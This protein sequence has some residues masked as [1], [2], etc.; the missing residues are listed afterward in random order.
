[1]NGSAPRHPE[2]STMVAFIEGRLAPEELASVSDH[3]RGC[4]DCRTVVTETARFERQEQRA[5]PF[6]RPRRWWLAVAAVA[7]AIAITVPLLWNASRTSPIAHLIAALP[8]EHRTINARLAGFPWAPLQAPA[9]GN[10]APDPAD[11]KLIGAAG[12]VLEKAT[13]DTVASRHAAGLADLLIGRRT[14]AIAALEQAAKRSNDAK[15]WNDLAAARLVLAADDE[16]PSELT[17]AL[18]AADRALSLDP[19]SPEAH[20]NRALIL[21]HLGI[22][23]QAS[24]AWLAY[25]AIDA[26]SEW[27]VEARSHLSALEDHSGRFDRKLLDSMTAVALVRQFPAEARSYGEGLLLAEWAATHDEARLTLSR[28]IGAALVQSSGEC[29]L[30]D[31]VAAIDRANAS[32]RNALIEAYLL[33]R[34]ARIAYNARDAGA[35]E[36]KFVRAAQLFEKGGSPM[37]GVAN[38]YVAGAAFAGHRS[39][40]AVAVLIR[41]RSK[42]DPRHRALAAQIEW[43]LAVAANAGGD[44][45]SGVRAAGAGATMF[46]ALGEA[47]NA[48]VLD[49]IG[50]DALDAIGDAD[51]AWSRRIR[52]FAALTG[53]P[54]RARFLRMSA[55]ILDRFGRSEAAAS[56]SRLAIDDL[57]DDPAQR[58]A[59]LTDRAR[60]FEHEGDLAAAHVALG[61][62]RSAAG[63]IHDAAMRNLLSVSIDVTDA[64]IRRRGD[65]AAALAELDR[66]TRYFS[67]GRLGY[68]LPDIYLERARSHR[69]AGDD[70]AAVADYAAARREIETQRNTINDADLRLRILDTASQIVDETI[71][72]HLARGSVAEAFR[73][74]DETRELLGPRTASPSGEPEIA[75]GT[76][77]LE[78]AVLPHEIAVFC[79]TPQGM[80][81]ERIRN[82]RSALAARLSS[83]AGKIRSRAAVEQIRGEAAGL[84]RLLIA[85][86]ESR[87]ASAGQIVIVP[88]RQL[89]AVPFAMLYN[90]SRREYLIER[91]AIRFAPTAS[92]A[93]DG[94]TAALQPA[95][96]FADPPTPRW[97][98]LPNSRREGE[99]IAAIY[100]ARLV[101]G[102]AATR[103]RFL[104]AAAHSA[105]IH[106]AGH[107]DSDAG[108]SYGALLLAASASDPGLLPSSEIAHL[109]MPGHPIVVLAA[110]G[111]FRGD[112]VHTAGMSSLTRAFLLAGARA[113]VGTLWEVDDDVAAPLFLSLHEQ[114]HAGVPPSQALRNAQL[115][116]I[117]ASDARLRHPATWAPIEITENPFRRIL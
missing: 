3:L 31:S 87:L 10:P 61:D 4:R 88:D 45:G 68:L 2:A 22:R 43:T 79:I 60:F 33:Y 19:K 44:W 93:G 8:R 78:Y 12:E 46:R 101:E 51:G 62:A 112:T 115:E 72:L 108:G 29:L 34:D 104:E 26:E 49:A 41:L 57:H 6:A 11:L 94:A 16:R 77:I 7:A 48:A 83:F 25:L 58:A 42:N 100:G 21:E 103:E 113:V 55:I 92:A 99:R 37:A 47:R 86:V 50:A 63:G 75:A 27:A 105:L 109:N 64:A 54:E 23:D 66:A 84:Y 81:V 32:E 90:E 67:V 17:L 82:E 74:A 69:A 102:E 111:T 40:E 70:A 20:F 107:A 18:A 9:R 95:V 110:C 14:D 97:P 80:T 28:A 65:P 106:Y 76:A 35:A 96:V 91:F 1:M 116:M 56:M 15:I 13:G 73:V 85:P 24:K 117:H 71:E 89:F 39:D 53:T 38:Y 52:S 114:L 30:A 59:A 36:P 5:V 98:R